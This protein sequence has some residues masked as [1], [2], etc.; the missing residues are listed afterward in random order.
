[1]DRFTKSIVAAVAIISLLVGMQF[2]SNQDGNDTSDYNLPANN[3]KFLR[4]L[5][6]FPF[7]HWL[8]STMQL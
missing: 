5:K 7:V 4:R 3:E 6:I 2:A 8:I 1:M